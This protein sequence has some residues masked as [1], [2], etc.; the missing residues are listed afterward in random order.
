MG[1]MAS[2]L[3]KLE[4]SV[5]KLRQEASKR[6]LELRRLR[7]E[8]AELRKLVGDDST[9]TSFDECESLR[10]EIAGMKAFLADYG[11]VWVGGPAPAR[12]WHG[13]V[14]CRTMAA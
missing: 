10:K 9:V 2:R 11:L 6:D 12:A 8:N 7:H 1:Q 5:L 3:R 14:A 4:E 13:C